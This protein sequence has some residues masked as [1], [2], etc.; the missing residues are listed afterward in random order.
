MWY[1]QVNKNKFQINIAIYYIYIMN[2]I[3]NKYTLCKLIIKQNYRKKRLQV[4]IH[5]L[6][7]TSSNTDRQ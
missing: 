5:G 6:S 3:I 4:S 1:S 7:Y 2:N